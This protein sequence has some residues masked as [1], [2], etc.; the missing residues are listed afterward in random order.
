MRWILTLFFTAVVFFHGSAWACSMLNPE[1]AQVGIR[2]G[3]K[4]V[5]SNDGMPITCVFFEGMGIECDG[6]S[7]GYSGYD[8][9]TLIFLAC[10]CSSDEEK[11]LLM[12]KELGY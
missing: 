8:L 4:G 2:N 6:P 12:Q 5:C 1:K 3:L 10:G 7:G 9:D 11:E